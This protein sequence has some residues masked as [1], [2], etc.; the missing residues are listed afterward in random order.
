M[1]L[2]RVDGDTFGSRVDLDPCSVSAPTGA[3]SQPPR[4]GQASRGA[5]SRVG[6]VR[7]LL[8][9]ALALSF[10]VV[11]P[12]LADANIL[13]ARCGLDAYP[14]GDQEAGDANPVVNQITHFYFCSQPDY[15]ITAILYANVVPGAYAETIVTD[16]VVRNT[17]GNPLL[18]P[19]ASVSFGQ[20][21]PQVGGGGAQGGMS[22]DGFYF[23]FGSGEITGADTRAEMGI[24]LVFD[25]ETSQVV[26][27]PTTVCEIDPPGVANTAGPVFFAD[28]CG[29]V[30]VGPVFNHGVVIEFGLLGLDDGLDL[31][32]SLVAFVVPEPATSLLLLTA[33]AALSSWRGRPRRQRRL[34]GENGASMAAEPRPSESAPRVL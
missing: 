26:V 19:D 28:S 7:A 12:R 9:V 34:G 20:F 29:P 24:N 13:T 15:L 5:E 3:V 23:D 14:V 27:P 25:F 11:A 2:G 22:M 16:F 18:P 21:H 6:K 33:C 31:P 10:V 17:S 8:L 32:G 4:Q 1:G 30:V